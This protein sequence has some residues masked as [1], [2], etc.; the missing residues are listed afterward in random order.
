MQC[1]HF[2]SIKKNL[3]QR[4]SEFKKSLLM[5]MFAM[6]GIYIVDIGVGILEGCVGENCT[7][8]LSSSKIVMPV[9]MSGEGEPYVD[10]K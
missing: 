2:E 9:M 3:S 4:E 7:N 10:E 6:D 8:V 1:W 5:F